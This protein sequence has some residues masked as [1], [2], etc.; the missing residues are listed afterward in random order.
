MRK[1]MSLGVPPKRPQIE[2]VSFPALEERIV[3]V[4]DGRRKLQFFP[5]LRTSLR[6]FDQ[7]LFCRHHANDSAA[8]LQ[9]KGTFVLILHNHLRCGCGIT[10]A[11][12]KIPPAGRR[13]RRSRRPR[14][15]E[16]SPMIGG[17]PPAFAGSSWRP[18]LALERL[19]GEG[20]QVMG[21]DRDLEYCL[22]LSFPIRLQNIFQKCR[23]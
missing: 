13:R 22:H 2:F 21:D 19:A 12:L 17:N 16:K 6:C 8:G 11:G 7:L 3:D 15:P 20:D 9:R 23:R 10:G 5:P 1:M 14:S 4:G 18:G